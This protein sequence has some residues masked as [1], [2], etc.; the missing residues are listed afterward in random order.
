[1]CI[2]LCP[3]CPW[4]IP[5]GGGIWRGE[6]DLVLTRMPRMHLVARVAWVARVARVAWAARV[7]SRQA[8]GMRGGV[9]G[10][11]STVRRCATMFM[12]ATNVVQRGVM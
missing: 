2:P 5:Y 4:S 3:W 6:S 11:M 9:R 10:A 12:S 7:A 8:G 1:M